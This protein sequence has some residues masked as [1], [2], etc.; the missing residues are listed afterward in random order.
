[1]GVIF[2]MVLHQVMIKVTI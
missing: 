2:W 1:M